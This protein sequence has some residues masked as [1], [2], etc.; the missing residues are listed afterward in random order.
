MQDET[1][2]VGLIEMNSDRISAED[3]AYI[4]RNLLSLANTSE[5]TNKYRSQVEWLNRVFEGTRAH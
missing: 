5:D 2:V 4:S 1:E 3:I